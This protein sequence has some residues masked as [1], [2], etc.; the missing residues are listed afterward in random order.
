LL[1]GLPVGPPGALGDA[2]IQG[3]RQIG[4]IEQ[5][6]VAGGR[7]VIDQG[8]E[9]SLAVENYDD[10]AADASNRL[11]AS[12]VVITFNPMDGGL[13]TS[14]KRERYLEETLSRPKD[15]PKTGR[16]R[17]GAK[18]T[19]LYFTFEV[20]GK[21]A[22]GNPKTFEKTVSIAEIKL[23]R[24]LKD[25]ILYRQAIFQPLVNDDSAPS[26]RKLLDKQRAGGSLRPQTG[27]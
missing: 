10:I 23:L 4:G 1:H 19:D 16:A 12:D 27:A 15:D 8:L 11:A 5:F 18:A 7:V 24:V 21:D 25:A 20:Q 13:G 22:K 14:V 2:L 9:D 6:A 3:I 26:Y 17:L